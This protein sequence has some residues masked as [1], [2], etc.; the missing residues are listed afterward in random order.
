MRKHSLLVI[1]I[2]LLLIFLCSIYLRPD[3]F[4]R[5]DYDTQKRIEPYSGSVIYPFVIYSHNP[6]LL[7][8][9]LFIAVCFVWAWSRQN[10]KWAN[11]C[12][13]LVTACSVLFLCFACAG[14]EDFGSF[15]IVNAAKIQNHFTSVDVLWSSARAYYLILGDGIPTYAGGLSSYYGL[16][17]LECERLGIV[18]HAVFSE[19]WGTEHPIAMSA[20]DLRLRTASGGVDIVLGNQVMFR[21]RS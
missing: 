5:E 15:D 6:V 16:I 4:P 21:Y 11:G 2:A 1:A 20:K 14:S 19:T 9:T 12:A 10:P 13:V 17:V 18:C 8:G 7:M 3:F